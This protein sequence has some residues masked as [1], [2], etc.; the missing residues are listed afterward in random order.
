MRSTSRQP[1]A[2]NTVLFLHGSLLRTTRLFFS[3]LAS[4]AF[5]RGWNVQHATPPQGAGMAY[6]HKLI[7]FWHPLGI[8]AV[9]SPDKRIPLPDPTLKIP[10]VYIDPDPSLLSRRHV[11]LPPRTGF[12]RCESQALAEMAAKTLL[13]HDFAAY[14]YVS[15]YTRYHCKRYFREAVEL[16][17]RTCQCFDGTGLTTSGTTTSERLGHWLAALPKPCGLLAAND[18]TAAQVL[19]V[20]AHE[21]IKVPDELSVLG[22]DDDEDF[23]ESTTPPLSSI[24]CDFYGGGVRAGEMIGTLLANRLNQELTDSYGAV[25]LTIR[26][27]TRRLLKYAP[28][29]RLALEMIRLRATEGIT[30]AD[31]IPLIGGSRRSAE[32]KFRATVGRSIL[33]EILNVRFE[34]VKELLA[35]PT[36]LKTV[37]LQAGFSSSNNLQRLFKARFGTTLS[38]YRRKSQG[39][40]L[41][42]DRTPST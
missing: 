10:F 7:S 41:R 8:V 1:E 17:G 35:T 3:G 19:S 27:S 40:H 22:I 5:K 37:A 11:P 21:G 26:Q 28:S 9:Y 16:N 25:R 15:A 23:C 6:I 38:D 14:A 18:R 39:E 29:I 32:R 2:S 34:K 31:V 30:A 12:I 42:A 4:V 33:E 13:E 24:R 20:A 36:P